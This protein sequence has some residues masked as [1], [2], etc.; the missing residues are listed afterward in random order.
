MSRDSSVQ[1]P[2]SRLGDRDPATGL[3]T[4]VH[5]TSAPA[6]PKAKFAPPVAGTI[7]QNIEARAFRAQV[8]DEA[9]KNLSELCDKLEAK[10]D[11]KQ[12][13]KVSHP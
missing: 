11:V 2:E 7:G 6:E 8:V 1:P 3:V 4:D 5:L 10:K 12:E 9:S 13:P